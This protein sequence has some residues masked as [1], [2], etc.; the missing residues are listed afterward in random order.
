LTGTASGVFFGVGL[1]AGF[2]AKP[3]EQNSSA[4]K[5]AVYLMNR[6]WQVSLNADLADEAD[7]HR[8][9]FGLVDPR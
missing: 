2:C 5:I 4:I 3:T 8:F 7:F 6:K 1:G 9:L